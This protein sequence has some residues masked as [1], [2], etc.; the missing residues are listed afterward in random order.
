MVVT[1]EAAT[2]AGKFASVSGDANNVA[3]TKQALTKE[4]LTK[5]A[6]S[7]KAKKIRESGRV[8]SS[9]R[10]MLENERLRNPPQNRAVHYK[11][12]VF[13]NVLSPAY[14]HH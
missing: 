12:D 10:G 6:V 2:A 1:V 3:F 7:G 11:K 13:A 9:R 4:A 8:A 5:T 14:F